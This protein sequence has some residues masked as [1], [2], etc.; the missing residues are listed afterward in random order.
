M[1]RR[2]YRL[3]LPIAVFS[4]FTS[5]ALAAKSGVDPFEAYNRTMFTF[6]DYADRYVLKPAAQGYRLVT[7]DP[8]EHS[9][10]RVFDNVGEVVNV[11]NDLLQGKFAQAGNDTGRLLINSTLGLVGIFD[12]AADMGLDK[13]EGEDFGQ[14]LGKWG[15][16]SGPYLIIPFLGASTLRD[17]PSRFVDSFVNP[18][19]T[20]DHVPTRNTITATDLLTTRAT[21]LDAEELISGDKY[22]FTRDVY[23]QR[24]AYLVSDGQFDDSFGDD[25]GDYEESG[26]DY[27]E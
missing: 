18:I 25:Y 13:S 26:E 5:H 12:V 15:V 14:T 17:G 24:R 1:F 9:V 6:N 23:L 19:N 20:L 11:A 3:A 22:T 8:V 4:L 2:I 16:G 21:F 7:P 27:S 10:L